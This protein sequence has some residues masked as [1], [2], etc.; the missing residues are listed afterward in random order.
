MA[1]HHVDGRRRRL[2]LTVLGRVASTASRTRSC[3]KAT[4]SPSS[5]TSPAASASRSA[6]RTAA[7]RRRRARRARRPRT[8][9]RARHA[10]CRASLAAADSRAELVAHRVDEP[11]RH[12]GP[13]RAGRFRPSTVDQLLLAQ[14][15]QQLGQQERLP[16]DAGQHRQQRRVGRPA[17]QVRGD[18]GDRGLVQR[19]QRDLERAGCLQPRQRRPRRPRPAHRTGPRAAT[20]SGAWRAA[21]SACRARPAWPGRPTARRRSRSARAPAARPAR[22][23]PASRAAARTAGR[24]TG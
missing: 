8:G 6:P 4:R 22:A 7:G 24:G 12:P 15:A 2:C 1:Q 19:G 16:A 10:I 23:I 14:P 5:V 9:G 18:A 11:Q 21:W 13:G 17:E 20:G 3:R